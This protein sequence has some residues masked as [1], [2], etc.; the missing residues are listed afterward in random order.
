MTLK[1]LC[2]SKL[3]YLELVKAYVSDYLGDMKNMVVTKAC[4]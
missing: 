1:H 2:I 3:L 4:H